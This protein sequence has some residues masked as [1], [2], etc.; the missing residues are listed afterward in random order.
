MAEVIPDVHRTP[1]NVVILLTKMRK[2]DG[3]GVLLLERGGMSMIDI[4][5]GPFRVHEDT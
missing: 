5:G 2:T 3:D 1:L 4:D